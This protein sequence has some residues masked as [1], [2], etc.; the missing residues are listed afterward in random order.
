MVE[1]G[2]LY[3]HFL[4]CRL[5]IVSFIGGGYLY[6]H[7]H[8]DCKFPSMTSIS[9]EVFPPTQWQWKN[10]AEVRLWERQERYPHIYKRSFLSTFSTICFLQISFCRPKRLFMPS[11]EEEILQVIALAAKDNVKVGIYKFR[12]SPLIDAFKNIRTAHINF[13]T[14]LLKDRCL[15]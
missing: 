7:F 11:S 8:S 5:L 6:A 13:C 12:T 10:W 9:C 15:K 1:L 2:L 14:C 3:Y 4:S